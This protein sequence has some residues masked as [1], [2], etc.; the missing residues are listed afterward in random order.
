MESARKGRSLQRT[1]ISILQLVHKR[2][3]HMLAQLEAGVGATPCMASCS[4]TLF[5]KT[6]T[7]GL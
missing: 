7:G 6:L 3:W 4:N 5:P 2:I 1:C